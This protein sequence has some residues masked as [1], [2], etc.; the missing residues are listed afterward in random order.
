MNRKEIVN[1]LRVIKSVCYNQGIS[2]CCENCP[3]GNHNGD[4]LIIMNCPDDWKFV[5]ENKV[6]QD[7]D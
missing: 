4:C 6:L 7:V 2:N 5:D 1:A 3:L